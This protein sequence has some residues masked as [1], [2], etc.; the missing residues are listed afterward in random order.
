MKF[1]TTSEY[2]W[3]YNASGTWDYIKD[4]SGNNMSVGKMPTENGNLA[5]QLIDNDLSLNGNLTMHG[6]VALKIPVG[7]FTC[8]TGVS[9]SGKSTLILQTLY[10]AF[11]LILNKNLSELKKI[12]L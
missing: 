11:N 2:K 10:N 9:G 1:H 3:Y 5:M 7:T 6:N 8:V 4:A 12:N